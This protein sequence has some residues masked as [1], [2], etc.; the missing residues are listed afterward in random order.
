MPITTRDSAP[1]RPRDRD[2]LQPLRHFDLLAR[3]HDN[4]QAPR[5][6]PSAG[7]NQTEVLIHQRFNLA[8]AQV[9]GGATR[10]NLARLAPPDTCASVK[11]SPWRAEG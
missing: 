9:S 3:L 10:V 4:L 8:L 1:R 5:A 6:P 2:G 11:L 7:V